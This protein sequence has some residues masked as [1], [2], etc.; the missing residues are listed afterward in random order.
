MSLPCEHMLR[1]R[2]S[3]G[4]ELYDESLVA[5]RWQKVYF[6]ESQG[7]NVDQSAPRQSVLSA[8]DYLVR[9]ALAPKMR[10]TEGL[11]KLHRGW[12]L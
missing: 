3:N 1:Y 7:L 10:N 4:D 11:F 5:E 8:A 2:L 9:D 6:L 12:L